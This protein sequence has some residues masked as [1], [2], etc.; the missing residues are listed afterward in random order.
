MTRNE[1]QSFI[2]NV[3]SKLVIQE[4]GP[5]Q[6]CEEFYVF[7]IVEE[8]ACLSLKQLCA[9]YF[10]GGFQGNIQALCVGYTHVLSDLPWSPLPFIK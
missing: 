3:T 1:D 2:T 6:L 10:Y 9:P 7:S 4:R 8:V 5:G